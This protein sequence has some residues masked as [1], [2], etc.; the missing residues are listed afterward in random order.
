MFGGDLDVNEIRAPTGVGAYKPLSDTMTTTTT[1]QRPVYSYP[2]VHIP[3]ESMS[4]FGQRGA[5][6]DRRG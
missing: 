4:D 3:A 2:V 5:A 6:H 1:T